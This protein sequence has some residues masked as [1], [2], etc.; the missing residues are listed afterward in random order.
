MPVE[1]LTLAAAL[2]T[3][4]VPR[5]DEKSGNARMAQGVSNVFTPEAPR[6]KHRP[7]GRVHWYFRGGSPDG[8]PASALIKA[9]ESGDESSKEL[10]GVVDVLREH[11]DPQVKQMAEKVRQLLPA[12]MMEFMRAGFH[13]V[14]ELRKEAEGAEPSIKLRHSKGTLLMGT[15]PNE[16]IRKRFLR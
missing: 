2:A 7:L 9:W 13:N 5:G 6:N 4:G 12:T 3:N 16:A 14:A 8:V 15:K 11:A 1:S 10:D